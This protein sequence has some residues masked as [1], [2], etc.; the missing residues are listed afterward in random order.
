VTGVQTCALPIFSV[1]CLIF[2]AN[3]ALALTT[4][5]YCVV[6][7]TLPFTNKTFE[8]PNWM[9]GPIPTSVVG[10]SILASVILWTTLLVRRT[11][12]RSI[13]VSKS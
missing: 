10:A 3:T 13:S 5:G 11:R 12:V 6:L 4:R 7:F 1:L 8:F 9:W 2:F